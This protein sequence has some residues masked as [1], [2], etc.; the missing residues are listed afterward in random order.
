MRL[1]QAGLARIWREAG[2]ITSVEY[3][4]LLAFVAAGV[5]LAA[6]RLASAVATQM[7]DTAAC[8]NSAASC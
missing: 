3:A 6:D 7:N 4:I 8:I 1:L 5:I 2:G